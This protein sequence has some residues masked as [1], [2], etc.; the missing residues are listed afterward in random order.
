MRELQAFDSTLDDWYGSNRGEERGV[1]VLFDLLILNELDQ[2]R[3]Y[4]LKFDLQFLDLIIEHI[5]D[6]FQRWCIWLLD[7]VKCFELA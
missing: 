7:F 6:W 4:F 5:V 1:N 3:I 2:I